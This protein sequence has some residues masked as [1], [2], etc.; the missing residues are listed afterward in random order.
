LGALRGIN[1]HE[2]DF[3]DVIK[4]ITGRGADVILDMVGGSYIQRNIQAAAKDGRIVN[5]MAMCRISGL[6]GNAN[7][8]IFP[9]TYARCRDL[10]REDQVALFRATVDKSREEPSLLVENVLGLDD[11][12]IAAGRRLLLEV[13]AE[14]PRERTVR[15]DALRTL[16]PRHPGPTAVYLAIDA[17]EGGRQTWSLGDAHRVTVGATLLTALAD[18]LGPERVH[19]R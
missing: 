10:L 7:A 5:I 6:G 1:Y 3:V 8:V 16:L 2:E 11:P 9:R 19:L 4:Q 17:D 14:T 15:V 18:V 13:R 12:E